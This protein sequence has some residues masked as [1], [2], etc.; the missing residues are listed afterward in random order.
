MC[1]FIIK[2][3]RI[4]NDLNFICNYV[5]CK[6]DGEYK[7]YYKNGQLEKELHY[8]NNGKN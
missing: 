2:N 3:Y 1:Y 8:I 5:D 6:D 4:K 7:C